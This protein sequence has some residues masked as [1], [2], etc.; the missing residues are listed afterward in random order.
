MKASFGEQTL[1]PLVGEGNVNNRKLEAGFIGLQYI[2]NNKKHI[3]RVQPI[4][5]R[6]KRSGRA[7]ECAFF[8]SHFNVIQSLPLKSALISFG[9]EACIKYLPLIKTENSKRKNNQLTIT[10]RVFQITPLKKVSLTRTYRLIIRK[11]QSRKRKKNAVLYIRVKTYNN[12]VEPKEVAPTDVQCL[13]RVCLHDKAGNSIARLAFTHTTDHD[14]KLET[15][16]IKALQNC[17]KFVQRAVKENLKKY[18]VLEQVHNGMS[19]R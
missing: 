10:P 4:P 13:S 5:A 3:G 19:E 14:L 2:Q 8:L 11:K 1:R 17:Y 12:P 9:K 7:E 6:T 16:R 15:K 18:L